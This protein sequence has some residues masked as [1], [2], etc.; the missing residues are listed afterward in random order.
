VVWESATAF[1][2]AARRHLEAMTVNV[3]GR[4]V[5]LLGVITFFCTACAGDGGNQRAT[6][7]PNELVGA[8]EAHVPSENGATKTIIVIDAAVR[9]GSGR[10]GVWPSRTD[11]SK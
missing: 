7:V 8:Y 3:N 10:A 2:L 6:V 1:I 5:L 9:S 11:R 4:R